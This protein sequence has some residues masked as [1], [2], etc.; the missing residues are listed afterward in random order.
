MVTV[1]KPLKPVYRVNRDGTIKSQQ[2]GTEVRGKSGLQGH[3]R[4]QVGANSAQIIA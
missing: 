3:I 1:H 4:G 2:R